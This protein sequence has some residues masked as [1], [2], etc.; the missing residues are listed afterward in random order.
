M[1]IV[2]LLL[3][4]VQRTYRYI[5]ESTNNSIKAEKKE[6]T[7]HYIYN[8]KQNSHNFVCDKLCHF[9]TVLTDLQG[10]CHVY[11]NY[12]HKGLQTTYSVYVHFTTGSRPQIG[13]QT[14]CPGGYV[15]TC[16]TTTTYTFF[17]AHIHVYSGQFFDVNRL[18][19]VSAS[20]CIYVHVCIHFWLQCLWWFHYPGW[21]L[22]TKF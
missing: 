16:K 17:N 3:N 21:I 12:S 8:N 14:S 11:N 20:I 18:P 22:Y 2:K 10:C 1:Y 6:R 9:C 4:S 15:S 19:W 7:V 5:H 13:W